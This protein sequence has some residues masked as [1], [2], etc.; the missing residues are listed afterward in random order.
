MYWFLLSQWMKYEYS[1]WAYPFLYVC[2][3]ARP[4]VLLRN[5]IFCFQLS[6]VRVDIAGMEFFEQQVSLLCTA[7]N[8]TFG[9]FIGSLLS[10]V[11]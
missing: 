6:K 2:W 3:H 9:I 1:A 10:T 11:K 4:V 7:H 8:F 5:S